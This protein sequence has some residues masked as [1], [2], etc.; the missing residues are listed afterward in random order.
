M[1]LRG[2]FHTLQ[3][4]MVFFHFTQRGCLVFSFN[5]LYEAHEAIKLLIKRDQFSFSFFNQRAVRDL[6]SCW[7]F[8]QIYWLFIKQSYLCYFF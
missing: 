5:H 1:I 2:G 8:K 4:L 6:I 7:A 3:L